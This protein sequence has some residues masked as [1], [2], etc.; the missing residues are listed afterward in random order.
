MI[1]YKVFKYNFFDNEWFSFTYKN[2]W[3]YYYCFYKA[4]KKS[5]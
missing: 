4:T 2:F 5:L 3:K 1:F